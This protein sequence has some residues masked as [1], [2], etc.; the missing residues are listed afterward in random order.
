MR[1]F[2]GVYSACRDAAWRCLIDFEVCRLPV[3]VLGIARRAGI[4]VIKDS[5]VHELRDGESGVSIFYMEGWTIVYDDRLPNEEARFVIAHELGHIF[6]GHEYRY[7]SCRFAFK[8]RRSFPENEAD[9][10]AARLLS[11]A[12]VLH[13]LGVFRARDIE[14]LCQLPLSVASVR[15][16]RM[17]VL[18]TRGC[19]YKSP[20]EKQ[21]LERFTPWLDT[22]KFTG[23]AK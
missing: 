14:S 20:L 1:D 21:L 18:E 23:G 19:Y 5:D 16:K 17:T 8:G 3:K 12:F 9:M 7:A 2:Y 4:R 11:P 6:L 22:L 15:A 13:E 10:F